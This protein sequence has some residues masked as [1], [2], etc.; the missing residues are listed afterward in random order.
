[1]GPE[2]SHG[3]WYSGGNVHRGSALDAASG[4]S[5]APLLASFHTCLGPRNCDLR[6][7]PVPGLR[8]REG[9]RVAFRAR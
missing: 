8:E 7:S 6:D 2:R 1:M 3:S 5:G 9:Q 4:E